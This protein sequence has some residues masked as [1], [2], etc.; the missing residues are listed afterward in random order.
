[1]MAGF[2]RLKS[3]GFR[4]GQEVGAPITGTGGPTKEVG[5]TKGFEIPAA[6]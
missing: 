3:K 2:G 6:D 4:E 1:M 5:L